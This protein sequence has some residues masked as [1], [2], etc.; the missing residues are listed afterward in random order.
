MLPILID[1]GK[2][3]STKVKASFRQKLRDLMM[4]DNAMISLVET[5]G[6]KNNLMVGF[7]SPLPF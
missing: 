5:Q 1:N 4:K 3:V 2:L 6:D 7:Q